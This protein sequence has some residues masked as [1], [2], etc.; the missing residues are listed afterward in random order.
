[1]T[2][3]WETL[4]SEADRNLHSLCGKAVEDVM[5]AALALNTMD[6]VTGVL[7]TFKDLGDLMAT[8]PR[9]A[10]QNATVKF[11]NFEA[12][13]Q[14]HMIKSP[15]LTETMLKRQI[16]S[17]NQEFIGKNTEITAKRQV[18]SGRSHSPLTRTPLITNSTLKNRIVHTKELFRKVEEGVFP[19]VA[20]EDKK[21]RT[22]I[23][24]TLKPLDLRWVSPAPDAF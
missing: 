17:R 1:M 22:E 24:R 6:N 10:S 13:F 21:N 3:I 2:R 12:V 11:K 18:I 16:V 4:K 9:K 15:G 23:H 8:S 7:V 14:N 20:S 19:A 5:K